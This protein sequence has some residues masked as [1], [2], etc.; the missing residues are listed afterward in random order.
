[1]IQVSLE[2]Q[3]WLIVAECLKCFLQTNPN[4]GYILQSFDH[5][6][7]LRGLEVYGKENVRCEHRLLN[8]KSWNT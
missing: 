8:E 4:I 3:N 5:R 6:A 7:F 1:M 2:V